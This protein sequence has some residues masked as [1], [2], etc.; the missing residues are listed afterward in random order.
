MRHRIHFERV[1]P[2]GGVQPA[3]VCYPVVDGEMLLIRKQRGLGAGKLIGAGGK[4]EDGETPGECVRREVREELHVR[5]V[6]VEQRGEIEFHFGGPASDGD[7][8]LVSVYAA[9]GVDGEPEPTAEATPVWHPVDD[10]P[11]DEMWVDDRVWLPH[12]LDGRT[13]AA[14]FVLDDGGE[15]LTEYAVDLD[16]DL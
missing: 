12:L 13:F 1:P 4:V 16:V 15:R 5:P 9:D 10:L 14:R 7:S 3:T 6:G 2:P 11:Y 8:L